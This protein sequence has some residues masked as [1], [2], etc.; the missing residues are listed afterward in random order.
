M[1]RSNVVYGMISSRFF[2]KLRSQTMR[3][4]ESKELQGQ[5]FSLHTNIRSY[6]QDISRVLWYNNFRYR[7]HKASH[8]IISHV[9]PDTSHLHICVRVCVYKASS[10]TESIFSCLRAWQLD[11]TELPSPQGHPVTPAV[12]RVSIKDT[13][14]IVMPPYA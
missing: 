5:G 4:T 8:S 6:S 11:C 13:L 10:D 1:S 14:F 7:V 2:K 3:H 9:V 12:L